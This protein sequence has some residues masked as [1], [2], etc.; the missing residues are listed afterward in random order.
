MADC[1]FL[2]LSCFFWCLFLIAYSK[3]SVFS[4]KLVFLPFTGQWYN[5]TITVLFSNHFVF[6]FQD[7]SC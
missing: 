2:L 1:L 3:K 5:H 7:M 6:F 4:E